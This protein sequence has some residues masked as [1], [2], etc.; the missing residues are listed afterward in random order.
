MDTKVSR[1]EMGEMELEEIET[2]ELLFDFALTELS[3]S[4]FRFLISGN[5]LVVDLGQC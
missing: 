3:G 4:A 1:G 2:V 5:F